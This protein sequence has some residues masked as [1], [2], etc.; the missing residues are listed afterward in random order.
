VTE[1]DDPGEPIPPVEPE[2]EA[3]AEPESSA[4]IEPAAE[5]E[6]VRRRPTGRIAAI[7]AAVVLLTALGAFVAAR[8]ADTN[9]QLDDIRGARRVAGAFGAAALTWDY[10]HLDV[11]EKAIKT[12]AVG[13]FRREFTD[14]QGGLEAMLAT[15]QSRSEGTV[16][17]V[18]I[19]EPDGHSVSA[20]VV[21]EQRGQVKD[22]AVQ[23]ATSYVELSLVKQGSHWLV[24]GVSNLEFG[25]SAP[26]GQLGAAGGA[27]TTTV[28]PK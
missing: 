22:G 25:G 28:P 15:V 8:Y 14:A 5:P 20:L 23:T 4:P 11:Y 10:Q 1:D 13:T 17:Q 3:E 7:I 27:T 12:L 16:K 18:Y 19:G 6:P 21:V 9:R 2:P 26:P 24:D